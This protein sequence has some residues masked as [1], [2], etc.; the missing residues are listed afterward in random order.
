[1]DDN[2]SSSKRIDP[3]FYKEQA[4]ASF[5]RKSKVGKLRTKKGD[6]QLDPTPNKTLSYKI[7]SNF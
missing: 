2:K 7:A 1:M 5:G 6:N 4:R 3:V